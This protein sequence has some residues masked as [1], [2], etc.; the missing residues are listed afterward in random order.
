MRLDGFC[1]QMKP[2]KEQSEKKS[3]AATPEIY[4]DYY[5]VEFAEPQMDDVDVELLDRFLKLLEG[6]PHSEDN[7]DDL[8]MELDDVARTQ[9]TSSG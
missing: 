7:V 3:A 5:S 1:T 2:L 6:A 4:D 9:N 8:S